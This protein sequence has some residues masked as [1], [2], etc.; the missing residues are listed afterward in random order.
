MFH[1]LKFILKQKKFVTNVLINYN[2]YIIRSIFFN[3]FYNMNFHELNF[4]FKNIFNSM[5][6]YI[7]IKQNGMI[8]LFNDY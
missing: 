2:T 6:K 4:E 3:T 7:I 1:I 8:F 5:K